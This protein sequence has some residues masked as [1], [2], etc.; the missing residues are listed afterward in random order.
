MAEHE[1]SAGGYRA[2]V[3]TEG[4]IV[5]E[6]SYEGRALIWGFGAE[7]KRPAMAGALLMPWPN[8]TRDGRYEF[9]GREYQ[10]AI[11]EEPTNNASHG[12]AADLTYDTVS[13]SP[14]E[15]YL[16]STLKPGEGYPW[17]LTIDVRLRLQESGLSYEIL[18]TNE[19]S[20]SAPFGGGTHPYLLADASAENAIDD[21]CIELDADSVMLISD[22]RMLPTELV[23]VECD[24]A[25]FDLRKATPVAGRT[26][27][28]A[29]RGASLARIT[30]AQGEGV[31]IAW[32]ERCPW[33]QVYT[34]DYG[35]PPHRR[36]ALAIEPMTCPPDALNS[37]MDIVQLFPGEQTGFGYQI[38]AIVTG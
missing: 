4:A 6:L 35:E 8:R 31:E 1:L 9:N 3:T 17:C 38:R 30:S 2:I 22:D 27:N 33:V 21:W 12:L 16:R 10:L 15:V 29:Y 5:R 24:A 23:S 18:V 32:D 13:A 19:S 20:S 28:H 25:R 37:K 14:R 7:E 26:L 11:N 36:H 34:A